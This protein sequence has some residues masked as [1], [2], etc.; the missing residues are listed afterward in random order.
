MLERSGAYWQVMS[1][2]EYESAATDRLRQAGLFQEEASA[3]LSSWLALAEERLAGTGVRLYLTGGN[4]DD[5]AVLE[6]LERHDGEHAV[7]CEGRLIELDDDHTMITVGLVDRDAVGH[8]ARSVGDADR[9][10]DRS[11]SRKGT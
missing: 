11:R 9:C 10:D 5:P 7:A 8:A 4:D 3:R 2:D 1:R 6:V